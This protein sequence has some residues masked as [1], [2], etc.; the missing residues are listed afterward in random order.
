MKLSSFKTNVHHCVINFTGTA[1]VV[2]QFPIGQFRMI[3]WTNAG[4]GVAAMLLQVAIFHEKSRCKKTDMPICMRCH[5]LNHKTR[6]QIHWVGLFVS[7]P[8]SFGHA[9]VY[10]HTL[11]YILYTYIYIHTYMW[12][13]VWLPHC[14]YCGHYGASVVLY[15]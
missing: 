13:K 3:G 14:G 15:T 8:C 12:C 6:T 2:A 4:V 7:F 5:S 11:Q 1:A 9:C 10:I